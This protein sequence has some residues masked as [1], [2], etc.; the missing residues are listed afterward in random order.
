MSL[1]EWNDRLSVKIQSIDDQHRKLIVM[2]NTLHDSM[3]SGG[4][5]EVV[6]EVLE[7][8]ADYTVKHFQYEEKIFAEYGYLEAPKHK[9]EH[10][11]LVERVMELK[12]KFEANPNFIISIHVLRFL[13]NWLETHIQGTD[14]LYSDFLIQRGV[15]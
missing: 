5:K 7:N 3:Q 12:N 6:G 11:E 1:I 10:D 8:L 2:I 9:K 15:K 13:K 4:S 14:K